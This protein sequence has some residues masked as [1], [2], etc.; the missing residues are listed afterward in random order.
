MFKTLVLCVL[1]Y[2]ICNVL[3]KWWSKL[4]CAYRWVKRKLK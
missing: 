1:I 2:F 4:Y 3:Y